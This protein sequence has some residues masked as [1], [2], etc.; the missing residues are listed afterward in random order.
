MKYYNSHGATSSWLEMEEIEVFE[1]NNYPKAE[2]DKWEKEFKITSNSEVIWITKSRAMAVTYSADL[3]DF[4]KIRGM[5][6]DELDIY[7]GEQDINDPT[8]LNLAGKVVDS[9]KRAAETTREYD[10]F[11][12]NI[13]INYDGQDE[14]IDSCKLLARKV[15]FDKIEIE[16]INTESLKENL[17]SSYFIPP[18]R[19]VIVS[20]NKRLLSFMLWDLAYTKIYFLE[21]NWNEISKRD[22]EKYLFQ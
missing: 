15:K 13:C 18:E 12:L 5:S 14:I 4:D 8:L 11:F 3:N 7:I 10:D 16:N 1:R 9:I 6:D 22:L 19:T 2:F 20:R 17:Y 21:K